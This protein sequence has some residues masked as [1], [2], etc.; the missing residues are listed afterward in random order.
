MAEYD[1]KQG[2]EKL[3]AKYG[4]NFAPAVSLPKSPW[5]RFTTWLKKRTKQIEY[6]FDLLKGGWKKKEGS[7]EVKK[8]IEDDAREVFGS[9]YRKEGFDLQKFTDEMVKKGWSLEAIRGLGKKMN[10]WVKE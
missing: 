7:P 8:L 9:F 3:R 4:W 10:E 2:M 5:S 1:L 6:P